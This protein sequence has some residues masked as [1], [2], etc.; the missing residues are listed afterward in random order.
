M[1]LFLA[2]TCKST[3]VS[4]SSTISSPNKVSIISSKVTIPLTA[5]N[6]SI[7]KEICSLFLSSLSNNEVIFDA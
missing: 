3:T 4:V 5:Q 7:T 6:S 2:K 1:R